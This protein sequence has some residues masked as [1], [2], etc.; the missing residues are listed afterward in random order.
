MLRF[1]VRL[2]PRGG[3]DRIDGVADGAL[4]ARVRAAPADGDANAA[5]IDLLASSL[6]IP[7][8]AMVI[9]RGLT[10]RRKRIRVDDGHAGSV[11]FAAW[12]GVVV[13]RD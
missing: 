12:P 13:E 11:T 1:W 5:L 3:S 6:H 9:D 2:T 4:L 10:S 7:R 8:S